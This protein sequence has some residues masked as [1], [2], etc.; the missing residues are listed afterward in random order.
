MQRWSNK[1]FTPLP[2][3]VAGG[4]SSSMSGCAWT[5]P[6]LSS[7][8]FVQYGL[9]VEE[10]PSEVPMNTSFCTWKQEHVKLW[11]KLLKPFLFQKI[12]LCV[13]KLLTMSIYINAKCNQSSSLFV[14]CNI[15]YECVK[16]CFFNEVSNLW[17]ET[18]S[19]LY[20]LLSQDRKSVV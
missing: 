12:Q 5:I 15:T 18:W 7:I 9:N 3:E 8:A 13:Y 17:L 20:L 11:L 10:I 6:A 4:T 14:P 2:F 1:I 19:Y 16:I